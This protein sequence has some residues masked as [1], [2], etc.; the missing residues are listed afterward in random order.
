MEPAVIDS[1]AS[2]IGAETA[3]SLAPSVPTEPSSP[4]TPTTPVERPADEHIAAWLREHGTHDDLKNIPEWN[5]TYQKSVAAALTTQEQKMRAEQA[6]REVNQQVIGTWTGLIQGLRQSGKLDEYQFSGW[7]YNAQ[8]QPDTGGATVTQWMAFLEHE[9]AEPDAKMAR[10]VVAAGIVEE[11]KATLAADPEWQDVIDGWDGLRTKKGP[12][13]FF[14]G[15][16]EL[17]AKK[18]RAKIPAEVQAGVNER[19][20]KLHAGGDV[21]DILPSVGE[22]NAS[23]RDRAIIDRGGDPAKMREAYKRLYGVDAPG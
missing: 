17:A 21:P 4:E 2:A 18:E 5:Q 7:R 9:R 23:E 14:Q 20:A 13:E 22:R 1:P 6:Q 3:P 19:L 16:A 10:G 11:L 12:L 15:L 8:G